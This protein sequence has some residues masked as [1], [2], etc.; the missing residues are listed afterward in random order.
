MNSPCLAAAL[1]LMA[2]V[3]GCVSPKPDAMKGATPSEASSSYLPTGLAARVV[4]VTTNGPAR[5]TLLVPPPR[6]P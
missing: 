3:T 2:G 4:T 1:A 6:T 5:M